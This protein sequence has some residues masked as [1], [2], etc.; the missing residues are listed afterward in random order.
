MSFQYRILTLLT[1]Y[2]F[3]LK[4]LWKEKMRQPIV[5]WPRVKRMRVTSSLMIIAYIKTF[6][7]IMLWWN[8]IPLYKKWV[9]KISCDSNRGLSHGL[10]WLSTYL[11]NDSQIKVNNIWYEWI[12]NRCLQMR[13]SLLEKENKSPFISFFST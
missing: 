1:G 5:I 2:F 11:S 4:N 8:K 6:R 12:T 9:Y 10:S 13:D 7:H 3:I